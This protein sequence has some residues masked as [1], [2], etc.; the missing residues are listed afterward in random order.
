M[1]S[2]SVDAPSPGVKTFGSTHAGDT[3]D[4]SDPAQAEIA[5]HDTAIADSTNGALGMIGKDP[6][7]AKAMRSLQQS[8]HSEDQ[9]AEEQLKPAPGSLAA[10]VAARNVVCCMLQACMANCR[11]CLSGSAA[12]ANP[13]ACSTPHLCIALHIDLALW[14][15]QV[16][17]A[18]SDGGAIA[19]QE[20][21]Y[22]NINSW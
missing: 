6:E 17:A 22:K 14:H 19:S 11:C 20:A 12:A 2:A 7:L 5:A 16:L 10:K 3:L 1:P 8:M 21:T 15:W 9:S 18:N 13:T 4:L